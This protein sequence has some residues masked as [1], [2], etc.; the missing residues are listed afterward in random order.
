MIK[1]YSIDFHVRLIALIEQAQGAI[2]LQISNGFSR[3]ATQNF[4]KNLPGAKFFP[5][6]PYFPLHTKSF[7]NTPKCQKNNLKMRLY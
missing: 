5:T 1:Y 2:F 7:K 3:A 6:L 4:G